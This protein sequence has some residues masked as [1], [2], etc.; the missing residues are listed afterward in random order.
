MRRDEEQ[1][2]VEELEENY[3]EYNQYMRMIGRVLEVDDQN[4]AGAGPNGSNL[5]EDK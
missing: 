3:H 5:P 1:K 2:N 4:L